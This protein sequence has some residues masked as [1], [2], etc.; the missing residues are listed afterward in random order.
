MERVEPVRVGAVGLGRWARVLAD[1]YTQDPAVRLVAAY[2]R[3]PERRAAFAERYHCADAPS[4]EALLARDDL[5]AVIVTVPNDQHAAVIEQAAAR[6]KH[7]YVEKPIA[8]DWSDAMRIRDAVAQARITFLCGHSARRLGGI[9]HM[10]RLMDAGDVGAVSMAEAVFANERGFDLKPGDWRGDPGKAPGGP[11]IQ[12]G[13]HQIDN[14]QYLLGPVAEVQAV[15]RPAF[16]EVPNETVVQALLQFENG[17]SAYLGN[18]WVCPGAFTLNLYGTRGNLFYD[19]DFGWWSKSGEVDRYSSLT[20]V[21]FASRGDDP[22]NR[23]LRKERLSFPATNHLRDE[24][25]EFA[26]SV[27]HQAEPEVDAA[28]A[29]RNLAVVLAIVRA[30][31]EKRAVAVAEIYQNPNH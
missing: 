29:I 25:H 9:R 26:L 24:I 15:G 13:V 12:L 5:E 17:A 19:L 30:M 20:K 2:S 4:L 27:R 1:Q 10:R 23:A 16:V 28:T 8:V 11:L 21:E 7:V 3:S 18:D 6:G 31:R 22:D 14:L